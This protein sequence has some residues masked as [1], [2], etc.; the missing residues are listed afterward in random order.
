MPINNIVAPNNE[1]DDDDECV[2]YMLYDNALDDG[3][4]FLDNHPCTTLVTNMCEDKNDVF[5][6]HDNT[7]ISKSHVISLN[8][9]I[10][11]PLK[12]NMHLL[13]TIYALC[14]YI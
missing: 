14:I 13:G 12:R 1:F 3:H 5:V 11:L 4:M 8:T 7:L 10:A 6:V 2:L 9:S